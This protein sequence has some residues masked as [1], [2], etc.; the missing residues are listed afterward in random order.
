MTLLLFG[1][2]AVI[3]LAALYVINYLYPPPRPIQVIINVIAGL[4]FFF[5][6]LA[7][8]GLMDLPFKLK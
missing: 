3:L 1:I 4:V 8:F 5:M 7:L 6:L 2:V